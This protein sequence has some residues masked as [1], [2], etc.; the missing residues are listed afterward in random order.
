MKTCES[1]G[2]PLKERTDRVVRFCSRACFGKSCRK[3]PKQTRCKE[4]GNLFPVSSRHP[5]QRFCSLTC[6]DK[7]RS[8]IQIVPCDQCG[9]PTQEKASRIRKLS[10]H[11]CSWECYTEWMRIHAKTGSEHAQ[12]NRVQ[13]VCE[14][15]GIEIARQPSLVKRHNFCSVECNHA[16]QKESGYISGPKSATWKGGYE[17][18]YGANWNQQRRNA[19]RRDGYMCRRCLATEQSLGR[20]LD[21]HHVVSFR[22]FGIDRFREANRLR[23]LICLCASCHQIIEHSECPVALANSL[24]LPVRL[25]KD[26]PAT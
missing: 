10:H 3:E 18:Y 12:Y 2:K 4:C 11:F 9:E 23:N 6:R 7:A 16:W 5:R 17:S 21:V 15:C 1:C 19:R 24:P 22:S 26:H 8:T 20:Q 13:V 14:H 25:E